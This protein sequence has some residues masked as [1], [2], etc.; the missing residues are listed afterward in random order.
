MALSDRWKEEAKQ[1]R[2]SWSRNP[3]V[4]LFILQAILYTPCVG[5]WLNIAVSSEFW[6]LRGFDDAH[7]PYHCYL[8]LSTQR[9]SFPEVWTAPL[10]FFNF[11]NSPK[12]IG[13]QYVVVVFNT[14]KQNNCS[15]CTWTYEVLQVVWG[16]GL[17]CLVWSGICVRYPGL[18]K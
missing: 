6:L 1:H 8:V 9:P 11:L 18:C 14:I 12:G 16:E 7:L 3:N 15:P 4:K 5:W 13:V 2:I 10:K 17:V